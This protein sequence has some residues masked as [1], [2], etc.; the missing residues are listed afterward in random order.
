MFALGEFANFIA[1]ALAPAAVVTP[2]GGLSVLVSTVLSTRFLG[3]SLNLNGKL[4]CFICLLGSTLVVLHAPKEQVINSLFEI[5]EK[6]FDKREFL[7]KLL[8]S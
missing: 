5:R 6:F 1:Y 7:F 8:V 3:E 2:L 4:G